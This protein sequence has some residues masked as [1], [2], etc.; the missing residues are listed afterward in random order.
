MKNN[1]L[2]GFGALLIVC[3]IVGA[4][5]IRIKIGNDSKDTS[6]S[7]EEVN[8]YEENEI[9]N[10]EQSS[11]SEVKEIITS[12]EI[13]KEYTNNRLKLENIHK[14]EIN[15]RKYMEELKKYIS[16]NLYDEKTKTLLRNLNDQK[17]D[18]SILGAVEPF[19]LFSADEKKINNTIEKINLTLRTYTGGYL[20][21]EQD[22]YMEGQ[23][24]WPIATLWMAMYYNQKEEKE[25]AEE[26]I[27]FVVNSCNEHGLLAEQVDNKTMTSNWVIGLGWSHAMFVLSQKEISQK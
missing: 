9:S 19:K 7:N 10:N 15:I 23:N 3:A 17:T 22:H 8:V 12:E 18:I 25:K 2:V 13:K 11:S 24:P 20:R 26:C 21:F 6:N 5:F 1:L 16:K 14:N 4:I 27:K